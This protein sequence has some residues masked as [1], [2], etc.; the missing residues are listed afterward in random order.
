LVGLA[1]AEVGVCG[2]IN[3]SVRLSGVSTDTDSS[4]VESLDQQY[5]LNYERVLLPFVNLQASLRYHDLQARSTLGSEAWRGELQPAL[6]LNWKNPF[7]SLGANY[8][9]RQ[10]NGLDVNDDYLSRSAGVYLKTRFVSL[11]Q[12]TIQYTWDQT[13]NNISSTSQTI[14]ERRFQY[15]TNYSLRTAYFYYSFMDRDVENL[16]S[17]VRE[18]LRQHVFRVDYSDLYLGGRLRF[19]GNY[20]FD[21]SDRKEYSGESVEPL[22]TIPII[23]GLYVEDGT[24]EFGTL[25]TLGTLIDGNL[26]EAT[27]PVINIGGSSIHQNIGFDL[28]LSREISE[29][30]IY[31]DRLSGS[32][33]DWTVYVSSDNLSWSPLDGGSSSLYNTT[34]K[35]F[36]ISFSPEQGRYFKAVNS[37]VN[38][39]PL[40]FVTEVQAL[41]YS[42]VQDPP[43]LKSEFHRVDLNASMELM[44]N[45]RFTAGAGYGSVPEYSTGQSR[46]DINAVGTIS[47][48]PT[49]YFNSVARYQHD[50]TEYS[51]SAIGSHE[52]KIASLTFLSNPLE[53]MEISLSGS[54]SQNDEND[55]ESQR[56]SSGLLH[57]STLLLPNLSSIAEIGYTHDDRSVQDWITN[58]WRYRI[59]FDAKVLRSL[60]LIA[61]YS[62]QDYDSNQSS[63]VDR[64]EEADIRFNYRLTSTIFLR[65]GG[66]ISREDDQLEVFQDYSLNWNATRKISASVYTRLVDSNSGYHTQTLNVQ[67]QYNLSNR[68]NLF[69]GYSLNRIEQEQIEE[70]GS[71]RIGFNTSF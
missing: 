10:A 64:R 4:R 60:N 15:S 18:D 32:A 1:V 39:E 3:G 63:S 53:T 29:I 47:Y 27:S 25:D 62:L 50:Y 61:G 26:A 44:R 19:A 51:T 46:Q 7:F 67:S 9:Y 34:L 28:G 2:S 21:Y 20:L 65:G 12:S 56:V 55:L 22:T 11:P 42:D 52:S 69:F 8:R 17:G 68:T 38:P 71:Y 57:L 49:R 30:H 13:T 33:V 16:S 23:Q 70:I 36:E 45:L 24:P 43:T 5:F 35:R 31:T 48:S 54:H 40:V 41:L 58:S 14:E 37:G 6:D 59:S 66:T